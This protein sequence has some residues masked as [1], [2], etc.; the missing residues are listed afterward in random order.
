MVPNYLYNMVL[1]YSYYTISKNEIK[2]QLWCC[3]HRMSIYYTISKNEIKPQL[4]NSADC[5]QVYYTIS[6]NE[7]KPQPSSVFA[8]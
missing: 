3:D 5:G 6:K 8:I 1:S 2:P 7:I 4:E